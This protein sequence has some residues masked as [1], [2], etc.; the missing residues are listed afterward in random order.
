[1]HEAGAVFVDPDGRDPIGSQ[2]PGD[3]RQVLHDLPTLT[4]DLVQ[5]QAALQPLLTPHPEVVE[6][7][8]VRCRHD[9]DV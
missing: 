9:P 3:G 1:M 4:V 8:Y 5:R 2:Q 7:H 6:T